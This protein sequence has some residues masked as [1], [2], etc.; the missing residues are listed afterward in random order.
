MKFIRLKAKPLIIL[1]ILLIGIIV[2]Y[3]DIY[4][5][6]IK[7]FNKV[8]PDAYKIAINDLP[9]N[10]MRDE[11]ERLENLL[12]EEDHNLYQLARI[13][14]GMMTGASRIKGRDALKTYEQFNHYNSEGKLFEDEPDYVLNV[15]LIQWFGGNVKESKE[16][17]AQMN[18]DELNEKQRSEV[19]I[20]KSA[21]NLTEFQLEDLAINLKGITYEDYNPIVL[22]VRSFVDKFY[23]GN[24]DL[25]AYVLKVPNLQDHKYLNY[26]HE[27]FSTL[28]S[29]NRDYI[30][31]NESR[32]LKNKVSGQVL[33]NGNPV[34]GVFV[35]PKYT[36]L[37]ELYK[38]LGDYK[39][40]EGVRLDNLKFD[41]SVYEYFTLAYNYFNQGRYSEGI[42]LLVDKGDMTID[43]DR[44]YNYFIIGDATEA[45]PDK[46]KGLIERIE[47]KDAFNPLFELIKSGETK[48]A[49]TWLLNTEDSE[50]KDFYMLNIIDSYSRA[51][52]NSEGY[53]VL[54]Y[55]VFEVDYKITEEVDF[56]DYYRDIMEKTKNN[57]LKE[58]YKITKSGWMN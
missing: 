48:E 44:H 6:G 7:T 2:F 11:M 35:Y 56:H 15:I 17:L 41:P 1:T 46:L 37:A 31:N 19:Y 27:L 39:G 3:K 18:L 20:I 16:L 29:S 33:L 22:G 4:W 57:T 28:R 58:I 43:G 45:L 23:K 34:A 9:V 49:Y 47:G 26:F 40:E 42:D 38:D 8:A 52:W 50:L 10:S 13:G 14:D 51:G 55:E 21:M 24:R 25:E 32:T 5:T 12:T 30:G 53:S 36:R 54:S